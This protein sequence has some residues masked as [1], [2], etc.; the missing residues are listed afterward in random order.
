MIQIKLYAQSTL[1]GIITHV[2][3]EKFGGE[4]E[5]DEREVYFYKKKEEEKV[6]ILSYMIVDVNLKDDVD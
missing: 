5:V 6:Q 4:I 3:Y 1:I 2:L